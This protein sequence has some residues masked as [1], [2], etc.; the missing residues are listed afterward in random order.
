MELSFSENQISTCI[1]LE[2]GVKRDLK[3]LS[4]AKMTSV[5]VLINVATRQYLQKY[6]DEQER[7]EEDEEDEG[8][9]EEE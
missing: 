4:V 8:D 5:S 7:K 6:L 3:R 9:E 2:E 1:L